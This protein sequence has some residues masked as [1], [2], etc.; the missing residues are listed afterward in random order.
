MHGENFTPA[1]AR[2]RTSHVPGFG[3]ADAHDDTA[4]NPRGVVEADAV[5]ADGVPDNTAPPG[6]SGQ[7]EELEGFGSLDEDFD[8]QRR[9]FGGDNM[10]M[11][12]HTREAKHR[13]G[14]LQR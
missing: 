13:W 9:L 1:G 3:K 6:V 10:I 4:P 12:H 8:L 14:C 7:A 2:T 11:G 5:G